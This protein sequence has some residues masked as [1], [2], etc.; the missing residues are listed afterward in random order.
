VR[1]GQNSSIYSEIDK[2]ILD[3]KEKEKRLALEAQKKAIKKQQL[4]YQESL[5]TSINNPEERPG[6]AKQ[7]I[8]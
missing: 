5:T 2:T 8:D 3:L 4:E 7:Y 1:T 6:A